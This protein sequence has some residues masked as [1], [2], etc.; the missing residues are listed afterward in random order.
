M[1]ATSHAK[2]TP[3][4]TALIRVIAAAHG[5]TP[6]SVPLT[7]IMEELPQILPQMPRQGYIKFALEGLRRRGTLSATGAGWHV[8]KAS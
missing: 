3:L 6:A 5:C 4:E 7:R 8:E 2:L 1:I